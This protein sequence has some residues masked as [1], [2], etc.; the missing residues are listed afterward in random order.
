MRRCRGIRLDER[1]GVGF[2]V[3]GWAGGVMVE[4]RVIVRLGMELTQVACGFW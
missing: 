3:V 4:G 2:I 1:W